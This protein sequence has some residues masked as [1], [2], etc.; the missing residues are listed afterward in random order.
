MSSTLAVLKP[1][2]N[3]YVRCMENPLKQRLTIGNFYKVLP[4][5]QIQ[6][7]LGNK[8][9]TLAKFIPL[10]PSYIDAFK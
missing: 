2:V 9:Y 7:D 1:E 10:P 4:N 6:D 5:N 8:V 3:T